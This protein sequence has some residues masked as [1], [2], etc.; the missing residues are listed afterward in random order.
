MST[1]RI[2]SVIIVIVLLFFWPTYLAAHAKLVS[3]IPAAD[4][5][6][7]TEPKSIFLTFNKPVESTF[8]SIRIFDA[9]DEAIKLNKPAHKGSDDKTLE[10]TLPELSS[11]KYKVSWRI[12]AGDGHKMKN[13]FFFSIK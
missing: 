1:Q 6:V 4:Q 10:V 3:S 8:S 9:H 2:N 5:V 12:V 11:G 7:E 13:E